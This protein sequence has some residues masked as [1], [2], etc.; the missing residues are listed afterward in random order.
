M[1][2][3]AVI[4]FI[5]G[6]LRAEKLLRAHSTKSEDETEIYLANSQ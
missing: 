2:G 5:I 1:F 4:N 3:E 6:E